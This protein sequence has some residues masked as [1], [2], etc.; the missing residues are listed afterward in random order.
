MQSPEFSY[1][2]ANASERLDGPRPGPPEELARVR[3]WREQEWHA[4]FR[5]RLCGRGGAGIDWS[6]PIWLGLLTLGFAALVFYGWATGRWF[7]TAGG[8]VAWFTVVNLAFFTYFGLQL[9][10]PPAPVPGP[11]A[12][13]V[14]V[15]ATMTLYPPG[16]NRR[17]LARIRLRIEAANGEPF[18]IELAVR[19]LPA[20]LQDLLKRQEQTRIQRG[21][22]PATEAIVE[23][24]PITREQIDAGEAPV[25]IVAWLWRSL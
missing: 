17:K 23:T 14:S 5:W 12:G 11:F 9:P 25:R 21:D 22:A 8:V 24:L 13:G 2:A 18:P 7:V 3:L 4:W 1:F 6:K 19:E 15:K 10:G 20:D 16:Y